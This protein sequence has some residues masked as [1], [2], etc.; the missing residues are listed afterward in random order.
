VD[1]HQPDDAGDLAQLASDYVS[2]QPAEHPAPDV[3]DFR[4]I[5]RAAGFA[6]VPATIETADQPAPARQVAD[7][8]SRKSSA[9]DLW[10]QAGGGTPSY[11]RQRYLDL[12]SEHGALLSP[13]DDGYDD[14][15]RNLPC[16][17]PG[18]RANS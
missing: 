13:G 4:A 12:L 16:G 10:V 1:Q 14:A 17:W 11:D 15:P 8:A 9:Y 3:P 2:R 7:H 5:A 18:S 6:D